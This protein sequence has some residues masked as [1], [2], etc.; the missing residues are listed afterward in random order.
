MSCIIL[1]YRHGIEWWKICRGSVQRMRTK[2]SLL[3]IVLIISK[4]FLLGV[5]T[6]HLSAQFIRRIFIFLPIDILREGKK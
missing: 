3:R 5:V 2:M 6:S 1:T 4:Y